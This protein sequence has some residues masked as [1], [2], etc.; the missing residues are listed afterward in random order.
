MRRRRAGFPPR[1][2]LSIGTHPAAHG[3]KPVFPFALPDSLSVRCAALPGAPPAPSA[4]SAARSLHL[5]RIFDTVQR[6]TAAGCALLSGKKAF[7][8]NRK[9]AVVTGASRGIGAALTEAL[10]REEYQVCGL[11][12]SPGRIPEADWVAC[13]VA[14]RAA[15]EEAFRSIYST[16]G[17][18]DLLV[19]NAGMGVS[20]AV[21]FTPEAQIRRQLEVNLLGA[22]HCTQQVLGPMREQGGGRILFTS[23]LAAIF[24]LPFQ[25]FYSVSKAGLDSFSDALRLEMR[26]FGIETCAI[27]LNDV[28]TGFTDS[29]CKTPDGDD[30]YCG[31]IGASV[32]KM[33]RSERSGIPPEQIASAVTRLLRR[34]RLPP[35]KIIGAGNELLG[36]LERLLPAQAMLFLLG[37]IYG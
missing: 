19:N 28:K 17:R 13:D 4:S 15:A 25:S 20:G 22:V 12:R 5:V 14:D 37:K 18:I 31:R 32:A 1:K 8:M 26:P 34:R 11:S 3:G 35:H 21:E 23:S 10:L 9:V 29:R 2:R 33:E 7:E 27:L 36:L 24:P 30:V 6:S 16:Y